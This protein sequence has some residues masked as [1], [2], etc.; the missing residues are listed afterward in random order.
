MKDFLKIILCLIGMFIFAK[1]AIFLIKLIVG[2][3]LGILAFIA[4]VL[5]IIVAIVAF[6]ALLFLIVGVL[7]R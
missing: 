4:V 1:V 3:V 7:F 2:A 5:G 6:F